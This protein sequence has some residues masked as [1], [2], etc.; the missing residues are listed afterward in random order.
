MISE[1]FAVWCDFV[2]QNQ[3]KWRT[4]GSASVRPYRNRGV[5]LLFAS[6]ESPF[7]YISTLGKVLQSLKVLLYMKDPVGKTY[8]C[9]HIARILDM[10]SIYNTLSVITN[11]C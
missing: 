4:F 1:I 11:K 10:C 9:E 5:A 6:K 3:L 7:W 2:N 8:K